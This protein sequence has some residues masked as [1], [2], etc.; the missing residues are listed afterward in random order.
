MTKFNELKERYYDKLELYV[1]VV[2]RVHG[3]THPEIH[4]VHE[5][6]NKINEKINKA[7]SKDPDL[8]HEFKELRK[9][10]SNY[11]I[12]KDTCESYEAVYKML[13]ELDTA[14]NKE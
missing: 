8:N 4:N 6:Y 3:K 2:S 1:P 10:T 9:I 14:Y 13:S 12:P 11:T 5:V 7:G